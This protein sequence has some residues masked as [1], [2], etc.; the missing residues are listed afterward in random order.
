[1]SSDNS[2]FTFGNI[3]VDLQDEGLMLIRRY[4]R[5]FGVLVVLG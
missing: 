3:D 4:L 1:M 5:C 2:S